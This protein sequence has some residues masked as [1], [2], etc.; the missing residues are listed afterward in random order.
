MSGGQAGPVGRC[1]PQPSCGSP[2]HDPRSERRIRR[3]RTEGS[4][5]AKRRGRPFACKYLSPL[6]NPAPRS[7]PTA[8]RDTLGR[9]AAWRPSWARSGWAGPAP[10]PPSQRAAAPRR[11][12]PS[13]P[14]GRWRR[15]RC[16]AS[17]APSERLFPG[18]PQ[19]YVSLISEESKKPRTSPGGVRANHGPTSAASA[20]SC[21]QSPHRVPRAPPWGSRLMGVGG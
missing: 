7:P 9:R 12:R 8:Q 5:S 18:V 20:S 6:A 11:G 15:T 16:G 14:A 19:V 2:Q 13:V 10:T 3:R 17:P 21:P 4:E 1:P